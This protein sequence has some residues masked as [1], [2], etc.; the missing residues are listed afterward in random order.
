M[1]FLKKFWNYLKVIRVKEW[2]RINFYIEEKKKR[3]AKI[4]IPIFS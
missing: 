3:Y 2:D 1:E 4:N